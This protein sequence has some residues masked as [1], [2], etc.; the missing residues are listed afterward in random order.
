MQNMFFP[1]DSLR[2]KDVIKKV[3]LLRIEIHGCVFTDAWLSCS[4]TAS[5]EKSSL[6]LHPEDVVYLNLIAVG[7]F[8]PASDC[9][10]TQII[11]SYYFRGDS[12]RHMLKFQKEIVSRLK[13]RPQK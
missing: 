8:D 5:P 11:S 12:V 10:F 9:R 7:T 13:T 2:L 4:E 3:F 1:Q 6:V